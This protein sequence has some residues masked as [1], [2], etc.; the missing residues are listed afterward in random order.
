MA[1]IV[2]TVE[3]EAE[4][5]EEELTIVLRKAVTFGGQVYDKLVLREPTAGQMLEWDKLNGHEADVKAV[6]VVS[7]LPAPAVHLL[8]ARDF[9]KAAKFIASFL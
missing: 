4:R 5:I 3:Q 8:G 9:T 7:G 1:D 2:Q 6:S